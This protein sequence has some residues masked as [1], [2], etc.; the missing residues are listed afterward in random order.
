MWQALDNVKPLVKPNGQLYIAIYNDL[1]PVTDRWRTIKRTY[2]R[3]RYPLRLLFALS[4]IGG[5]E[6]RTLAAHLRRHAP[7]RDYIRTWTQYQASRGMNRWHDWIDWIGG[8][9]YECA[10]FED[11]IDCF[12][13]DGFKLEWLL[14]RA[15]GTG[16]N[17]TVF[18]RKANLGVAIDNLVPKSRLLL[19]RSGHLIN[20]PVRGAPDGYIAKIP[21]ALLSKR[22]EKMVLFRDGALSGS[23][24]PGS[25]PETLVVA[26]S[27]WSQKKVA[28]TKFHVVAGRVRRLE[29]PFKHCQGHKFAVSVLDLKE[30]ADDV[31][32][33]HDAS[34]IF[35]FED[36]KQLGMPHAIHAEIVKFGAGRFSHWSE[37]LL[38][39]S[40]DNS[41]PRTNGRTYTIVI[42][43]L[44]K[45][46][47][48][49]EVSSGVSA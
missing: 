23:A 16:C 45:N 19:R 13:K 38:F 2:N 9:P 48:D 27:E 12:S 40:S 5:Y 7:L 32:P 3:L 30:V 11:L 17:E 6:L 43:E 15:N 31:M 24:V 39:S 8:F 37:E 49:L 1:G 20:T 29:L 28:A 18:R 22:T 26:P 36:G 46:Y 14:S 34:P 33:N 44:E 47:T 4:I 10:T 21:D 25:E 35:I 42:A 41:D